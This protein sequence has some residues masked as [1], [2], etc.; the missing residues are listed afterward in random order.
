LPRQFRV[1]AAVDLEKA[2]GPPLIVSFDA[3]A[4][5]Y[6]VP[7]G[8]R[9]VLALGAEHWSF[10]RRLGLRGGVRSNRT[11]RKESAATGGVSVAVR[12]GL[13]LEGH[14]VGS[15]SPAERGWGAAVRVSF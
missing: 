8:P 1:G 12:S 9:R 7:T 10:S 13:Y 6:D 11:G 4:R 5:R 15:G 14:I 3:D 2:G